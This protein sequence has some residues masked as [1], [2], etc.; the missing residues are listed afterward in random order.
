VCWPSGTFVDEVRLVTSK[1]QLVHA[2][3]LRRWCAALLAV[4]A[5]TA[6]VLVGLVAGTP[7]ASAAQSTVG[8]GT[9]TSFAVLAGSTVTNTGPSQITGNLGVSPGAA[10]TGF[11]PGL[12]NGTQHK[13]DA[14]ALQAQSDL[15]TGYN[16][17]A[18]RTPPTAV[19]SDLGGQKLV[20]GVYKAAGPLGLT[21]TLT[22]D[23]Q[24]N[25]RSVFIFQAGST[26]ITA[27]NSTVNLVNGASPCNVFWQVGSSATLGTG[28]TFVGSIL[29]LTSASL[30]TGA[31]VNGRILARNGAVTLDANTITR[32]SCSTTPTTTTTAPPTTTNGGP[33]G[34]GNGG[35]TTTTT[36]PTTTT[37][38]PT[39][40][41]TTTPPT[42]TNGGPGGAGNGGPTTTTTAPTTNNALNGGAG[43]GGSGGAAGPG[44]AGNG[45]SGGAGS[46]GAVGSGGAAGSAGSGGAGNGGS[47]GSAGSGGAGNGGSGGSAGSAGSGGAGNGG[48]GGSAGSGGAGNGGSAGAGGAGNGSS[49]GAAGPGGAGNGS[50]GGSAGSAGSAGSGG[51][52]SGGS[53]G[54]GGAGSGGSAGPGG[55]S[56]GTG[57]GQVIPLGHPETGA[58]GASHSRNNTLIGLGVLALAGAGVAMI[59][60]TRRRRLPSQGPGGRHQAGR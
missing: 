32:P 31:T 20:A 14:V 44:G 24:N 54:S 52:G 36:T 45:G 43:N 2:L 35:P 57:A 3:S 49:G 39:T 16:D 37:N 60:D 46:G 7:A 13:A 40:T 42:T 27:S 59:P 41:T 21:G 50:S 11:P 26:L 58:G 18:G 4:G 48:S 56:T 5:T 51:A 29:A 28:T 22:L 53:A 19:S 38:P 30:N 47:G 15:T 55:A 33:G 6:M 1:T 17:A 8:L 34:A 23:A 12:V 9:A 25:P 10:V